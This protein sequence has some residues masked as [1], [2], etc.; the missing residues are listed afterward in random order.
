M[1][2]GIGNACGALHVG[3]NFLKALRSGFVDARTWIASRGGGGSHLCP[4]RLSK[5][6]AYLALNAMKIAPAKAMLQRSRERRLKR[7]KAVLS[8]RRPN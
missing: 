5:Q 3:Y 2:A 8:S 7:E 1:P 4:S 6:F